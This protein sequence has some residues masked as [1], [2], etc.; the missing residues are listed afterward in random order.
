MF[1][2]SCRAA[3]C[4]P[5]SF[6]RLGS[7]PPRGRPRPVHA[8]IH[9]PADGHVGRSHLLAVAT[10]AAGNICELHVVLPRCEAPPPQSLPLTA[11]LPRQPPLQTPPCTRCEPGAPPDC[12]P[13]LPQPLTPR[14]V[15]CCHGSSLPVAWEPGVGQAGGCPLALG[16]AELGRGRPAAMTLRP[17]RRECAPRSQGW[18]LTAAVSSSRALPTETAAREPPW[19]PRTPGPCS[20]TFVV[21]R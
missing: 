5:R 20:V 9:L 2:R 13:V 21:M 8:F 6:L 11:I 19:G 15:F 4:G 7:V 1:S 10:S 3:A 12:Q 16:R 17:R 18:A 14:S